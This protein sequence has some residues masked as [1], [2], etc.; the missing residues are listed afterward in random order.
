VLFSCLC[1]SHTLG[2]WPFLCWAP[3]PQMSW[4]L[5]SPQLGR[6][7][8]CA[9]PWQLEMVCAAQEA[10]VII[11]SVFGESMPAKGWTKGYLYELDH[12]SC[13]YF[14][15]AAP[16]ITSPSSPSILFSF[17]PRTTLVL[18]WTPMPLPNACWSWCQ[19]CSIIPRT[20]KND[21]SHKYNSFYVLSA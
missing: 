15:L 18:F 1:V 21:S 3:S 10:C 17:L 12:V 8:P 11:A 14:Y 16:T 4:E 13:C 6:L 9:W 2:L 20:I 7:A 5:A 19:G